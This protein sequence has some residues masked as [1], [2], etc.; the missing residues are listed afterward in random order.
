MQVFRATLTFHDFLFY[1][2]REL[3]V[4]ITADV[5]NNT[6]LLYAINTLVPTAHRNASGNIPH[7][8]ED[9][10][11]FSI[12]ATPAYLITSNEVV[13]GASCLDFAHTTSP[14]KITYNSVDSTYIIS[15]ETSI[16]HQKIKKMAH[17]KM[18][19]YYKYPPLT[20]FRFF[21]INGY[22]SRVMR[23][24]KKMVPA[25]VY[26][27]PVDNIRIGEGEFQPSH[28]VQIAELPSET[29]VLDASIERLPN[30]LIA[31]HARLKGRY[32]EGTCNGQHQVITIPDQTRYPNVSFE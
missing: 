4:G 3:K 32:L 20:S 17:P 23:L 21:T 9:F 30:G 5:V 2:S 10:T 18:G 29:T 15:M 7:Y 27:E 19:S 13:I 1:V 24:G 14:V 11:R 12:Y 31:K 26:Y 16:F 6:A 22:G 28:P 8:Y 25:T